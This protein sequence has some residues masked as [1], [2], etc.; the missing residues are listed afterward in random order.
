[1]A[2]YMNENEGTIEAHQWFRNGDHP[3]DKVGEWAEDQLGGRYMRQEGAVVQFFRHPDLPGDERHDKC[4]KTW[5]DHGWI[6]QGPDGITVCPGDYVHDLNHIHV[7]IGRAD[8]ESVFKLDLEELERRILALLPPLGRKPHY[9]DFGYMLPQS[10]IAY[11]DVGEMRDSAI[12][13]LTRGAD[14]FT[15]E[16]YTV[17]PRERFLPSVDGLLDDLQQY[18]WDN[19]ATDAVEF[20]CGDAVKALAGALVQRM[21]DDGTGWMTGDLVSEHTVTLEGDQL[22]LDGR[23]WG[24][25]IQEALVRGG[26]VT[27]EKALLAAKRMVDGELVDVEI[28]TAHDRDG[29][30]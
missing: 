2:Q 24:A 25:P 7:R 17:A 19:E 30:R 11:A 26:P 21:G 13:R 29:G 4:G 10:E 23:A 16:K 1:M 8:F 6:D 3:D 20:D 27:Q 12:D 15:F 22:M 18:A 9:P 28:P 5:H 14:S